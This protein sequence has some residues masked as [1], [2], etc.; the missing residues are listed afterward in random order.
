[1]IEATR[2]RSAVAPASGLRRRQS[3]TSAGRRRGERCVPLFPRAIRESESADYHS[4]ASSA[5]RAHI[6]A[7][8]NCG[9][10]PGTLPR[11][12]FA[13]RPETSFHEISSPARPC[14]HPTR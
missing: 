5:N 1:L 3:A 12:C 9:R 14:R 13:Y 6:G 8:S 7:A 2:R 10:E 4:L 11:T